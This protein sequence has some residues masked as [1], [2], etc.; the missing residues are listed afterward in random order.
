MAWQDYANKHVNTPVV[1]ISIAFNSGTRYYSDEYIRTSTQLYKGNI[2]NIPQIKSSIGDIKRTYEKSK[3]TILF[4][5][6]DY[7]FRTLEDTES[8]SVKKRTVTIKSAFQD[9]NYASL[10]TLYTGQIYDWRRLDDLQF[11]IDVEEKSLNLENEYPDK[12]VD[13]TD[14]P[15]ADGSAIGWIIPIPYGTISAYGSSND[16]A[17]GHPSLDE[18]GKAGLLMVDNRIDNEKHLVGR[19]TAAITVSRAYIDGELKTEGAAADYT[20]STQVIDGQTH[21]EIHW[22]AGVNPTNFNRISCDIIFGSRRPVEGIKHFLEN[23]CGYTA[24]MFNATS[25]SAATT[26]EAERNYTF[27]GVL[28]EKEALKTILDIWREEFELDI[29]WNNDGEICFN[30]ISAVFATSPNHYNDLNDILSGFD[31]DPQTTELLNKLKYG[32]NFH[33]SKTY[34]Y[35]YSTR[36]DIA[37]QTKYGETFEKFKGFYWI[38]SASMAHDIASRKIIR[39]KDPITFDELPFPLKTFSDELTDMLK[40]T[41]FEGKGASGY[42]E[43]L[44]QI[45]GINYDIDNFI[46]TMLLEDAS[47]FTGNA[48]ILGDDTVLPA[49]WTDASGAEKDYCYLASSA[50]GTFSNG[51][52]GKRLFD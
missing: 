36:E 14:Y 47:N 15:Y 13:L 4:N 19:Q 1:L 28:W 26:K 39:F 38:R 24:G 21:T 22:N 46:N 40:I 34:F 29:F 18:H 44:F 32:Y 5:D 52:P 9:D 23:F 43:K 35:N 33:Y 41:H 31:S 11:E 8:V 51:E 42:A 48:C 25:Y 37:S 2:L 17:Y 12:R 20:I 16:G 6:S 7:E 49:K 3:I 45:R 27:D 10:F 50:T 30:Y